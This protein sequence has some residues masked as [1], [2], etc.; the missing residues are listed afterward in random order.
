MKLFISAFSCAPSLGSE[1]A[2]GWNGASEAHHLARLALADEI[3]EICSLFG[4]PKRLPEL[5]AGA[6][7]R[8]R[9]FLFRARVAQSRGM[10]IHRRARRQPRGRDGTSPQKKPS[11]G[12]V[13]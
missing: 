8:A 1:R 7:A 5:S 10:E 4:S 13:T 9:E 12:I 6:I 2:V 11:F 3:R